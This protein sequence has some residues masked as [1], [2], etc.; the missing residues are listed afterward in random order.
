MFKTSINASFILTLLIAVTGFAQVHQLEVDLSS[1]ELRELL[2]QKNIHRNILHIYKSGDPIGEGLKYGEKL[3]QWVD[4]IN[5]SRSQDR[6][7]QLS[8]PDKRRSY[9]IEAP[10]HYSPRSVASS[11]EK[12]RGEMPQ[13][14][15]DILF[16][17]KKLLAE[18]PVS[19]EEFILSG[20]ALDRIYQTSARWTALIGYKQYFISNRAR[21]VRGYYFLT[22]NNWNEST[23]ANWVN[24]S[25]EDILKI[26]EAFVG[27]CMNSRVGLSRCQNSANEVSSG[28]AAVS[29]YNRYFQKSKDV[30]DDFFEIQ[31]HR[32][33][34]TWRATTPDIATIP[35]V[36]PVRDEVRDFI[37]KNI[38][39]EF[40][41]LNWGLKIN[42]VSKNR[43]P[44]V[45]FIPGVTANVEY[46]GGNKIEMDANKSLQE[47]EERWTIR[48]EF[49]HVL[50]IPDCYHEFYDEQNEEF[51]NYQIDTTDLMC[52]RAGNFSPRIYDQ[53]KEAYMTK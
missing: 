1:Q 17:D 38:E 18:N 11:L 37:K 15:Q 48:H 39:E 47:F 25:A 2:L 14:M 21:D 10:S 27:I 50:G 49:G 26:K 45:V 5:A 36:D 7:I 31:G 29:F 23:L 28:A 33:D 24:L 13:A 51:I 3:L 42:F 9:P 32:S 8:S 44:Y 46:L 41:F 34:I 35:F 22:R 52:S 6:K 43:A 30:Y 12:L 53:L 19:D 16:T 4:L 20:R 40:S